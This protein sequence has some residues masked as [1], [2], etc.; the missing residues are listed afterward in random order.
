MG[1]SK[2]PSKVLKGGSKIEIIKSQKPATSKESTLDSNT[3][4][5]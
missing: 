4:K 5:D 2:Y 1:G 3:A